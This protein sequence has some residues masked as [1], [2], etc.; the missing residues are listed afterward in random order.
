MPGR[1]CNHPKA[2]ADAP[3]GNRNTLR[4]WHGNTARYT[5]YYLAANA[6]LLGVL[7]FFVAAPKYIRISPLEPNNMSIFTGK[8]D[9]TAINLFLRSRWLP[10]PFANVVLYSVLWRKVK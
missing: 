6:M 5:W 7:T 9:N 8:P 4:G 2:F 10:C 3:A 1:A